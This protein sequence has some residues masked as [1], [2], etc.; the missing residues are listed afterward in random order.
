MK[1]H[2]HFRETKDLLRAIRHTILAR[3]LKRNVLPKIDL[4]L[5]ASWVPDQTLYS[6]NTQTKFVWNYRKKI[7]NIALVC[8]GIGLNQF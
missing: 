8:V 1:F 6:N 2:N 7:F 3:V 5:N 4:D